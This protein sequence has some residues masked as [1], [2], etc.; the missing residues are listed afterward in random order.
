[1]LIYS[2]SKLRTNGLLKNFCYILEYKKQCG[3]CHV[4]AEMMEF[5]RHFKDLWVQLVLDL[6]RCLA[7]IVN[8]LSGRHGNQ[9]SSNRD[10]IL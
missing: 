9:T 1:M 3:R 10:D 7:T 8:D 4:D 6:T 2:Q 5:P